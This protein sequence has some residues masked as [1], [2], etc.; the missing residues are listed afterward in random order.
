MGAGDALPAVTAEADDREGVRVAGFAG[1][2]AA[3]AEG[4][5]VAGALG[6]VPA[7]AEALAAGEDAEGADEPAWEPAAS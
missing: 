4:V 1:S 5:A 2:V 6:A 7:G 3:E